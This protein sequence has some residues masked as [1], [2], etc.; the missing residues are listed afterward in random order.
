MYAVSSFSSHWC[1]P[2]RCV[3]SQ[4]QNSFGCEWI[5]SVIPEYPLIPH[6]RTDT[7]EASMASKQWRRPWRPWGSGN[8]L[9]KGQ[10]TPCRC[11]LQSDTSVKKGL[12]TKPSQYYA[13]VP[14]WKIQKPWVVPGIVLAHWLRPVILYECHCHTNLFAAFAIPTPCMT[15]RFRLTASCSPLRA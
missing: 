2:G 4:Y 7:I 10:Q 6:A 8:S 5:Q 13:I 9:K 14:A 12:R 3:P 15:R 1:P 11:R